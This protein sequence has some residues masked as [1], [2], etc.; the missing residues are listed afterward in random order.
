LFGKWDRVVVPVVPAAGFV[1]GDEQDAVS[2]SA[3]ATAASSR[4]GSRCS[5]SA[6]RCRVR[7]AFANRIVGWATDPRATTTLVVLTALNHALCSRDVRATP[8][9][10]FNPLTR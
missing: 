1:A 7:D 3:S 6:S 4:A 2:R 10:I 9:A 5:S 8:I